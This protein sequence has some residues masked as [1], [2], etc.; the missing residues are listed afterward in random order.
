[1]SSERRPTRR[2]RRRCCVGVGCWSDAR[3]AR[4]ASSSSS[5]SSQPQQP[6]AAGQGRA[7]QLRLWQRGLQ[8]RQQQG[9]RRARPRGSSC[10]SRCVP[11]WQPPHCLGCNCADPA[12]PLPVC[13]TSWERVSQ[14]CCHKWWC[15]VAPPSADTQ[16]DSSH[17][18]RRDEQRT[19]PPSHQCGAPRN[20]RHHLRQG[21]PGN[22]RRLPPMSVSKTAPTH[23]VPA[24]ALHVSGAAAVAATK[25]WGGRRSAISTARRD[26]PST[27]RSGQTAAANADCFAPEPRRRGKGLPATQPVTRAPTSCASYTHTHAHTH[28]HTHTRTHAHARARAAVTCTT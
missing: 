3:W 9:P 12:P 23:A 27:A 10:S 13:R 18:Q 24:R 20:A 21:M 16:T 14:H 1:V 26:P 28:T 4:C 2:R 5:S 11:R 25:N 8:Q 22:C 15:A 7:L 19:Q 17:A 6:A